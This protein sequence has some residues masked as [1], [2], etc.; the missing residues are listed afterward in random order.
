MT[1]LEHDVVWYVERYDNET[2]SWVRVGITYALRPE[3]DRFYNERAAAMPG[4]IMRL[5]QDTSTI[6][7]VAQK[8]APQWTTTRRNR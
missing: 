2:E 4:C 1:E 8:G 6:R 7:V 3:A 5:V